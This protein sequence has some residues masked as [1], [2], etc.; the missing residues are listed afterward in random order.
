MVI[1][2]TPS[3]V[4]VVCTRPLCWIPDTSIFSFS[5]RTVWIDNFFQKRVNLPSPQG[6]VCRPLYCLLMYAIRKKY[7]WFLHFKKWNCR[8][9]QNIHHIIS[10][11]NRK[12]K[13]LFRFLVK[14]KRK[15]LASYRV[16]TISKNII[17]ACLLN[18]LFFIHL[19]RQYSYFLIPSV[20][21][22]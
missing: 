20:L 14:E 13:L 4:N 7:K 11:A 12:T 8:R 9:F 15:S 3:F 16:C 19:N 18:R 1:W 2:A 21:K 6:N 10:F 17:F 5:V 22:A